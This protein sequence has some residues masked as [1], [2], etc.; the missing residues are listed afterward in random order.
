MRCLFSRPKRTL[1]NLP[2]PAFIF[3]FKMH[4]QECHIPLDCHI[5]PAFMSQ[6]VSRD[7]EL[8]L[9]LLLLCQTCFRV[10]TWWFT[11]HFMSSDG[12]DW[13]WLWKM[14]RHD[15]EEGK[16][17]SLGG[18]GNGLPISFK[19]NHYI[20]LIALMKPTYTESTQQHINMQILS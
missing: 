13:K 14:L 11:L 12:S 17:V 8:W 4:A 20:S 18:F 1:N 10:F 16:T 19:W 7:W 15:F 5:L 3:K 6:C 9:C 2:V